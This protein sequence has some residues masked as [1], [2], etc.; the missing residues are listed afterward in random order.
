LLS[1]L[2]SICTDASL[3]VL[4]EA[5]ASSD[6]EIRYYAVR[7]LANIG[8]A[9]A[10]DELIVALR[11]GDGSMDGMVAFALQML[12]ARQAVPALIERLSEA[13]GHGR[14]ESAD[15]MVARALGVVP[16]PSAIPVLAKTVGDP[17]KEV[18]LAA[19]QALAA[20]GPEGEEAFAAATGGLS[21]LSARQARRW[22]DGR[23]AVVERNRDWQQPVVPIPWPE[24]LELLAARLASARQKDSS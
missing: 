17:R 8:S 10:I 22:F 15:A 4:R 14:E 7:G 13:G 16:D 24:E 12:R 19:A 2:Q 11:T 6:F 23:Q 5:L 18:R 3:G 21:W 20:F 9:A 1:D